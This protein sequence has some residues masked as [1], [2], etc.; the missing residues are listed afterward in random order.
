MMFYDKMEDIKFIFKNY[1]K[2]KSN[3]K[4][5][6]YMTLALISYFII[7]YDRVVYVKT[8]I[9]LLIAIAYIIYKIAYGD[10]MDY[11]GNRGKLNKK[12]MKRFFATSKNVIRL[13]F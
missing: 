3:T 6:I 1:D 13:D 4:I 10:I 7:V 5:N 8:I 11:Y 2:L 9:S 12:L